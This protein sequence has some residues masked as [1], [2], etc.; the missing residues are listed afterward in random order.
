MNNAQYTE[1]VMCHFL[2][3]KNMGEMKN[4]DAVGTVGNPRCGDILKI[5][6]KISKNK[7]QE[8][9]IKNIKF[10][11]FGCT[12]AIASSSVLT[13]LAKGLTIKKAKK[14]TN[15]DVASALD[16]LPPIKMHCSNLAADALRK[17]I[18]EWEKK[19]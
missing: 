6:I 16:S 8:P 19:K 1:K 3:P 9:I 5:M 4:P 14:I 13:T 10:Q 17:A 7:Q 18:D 2:H 12:A 15:K 11:T